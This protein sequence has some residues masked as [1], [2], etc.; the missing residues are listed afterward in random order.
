MLQTVA[1]SIKLSILARDDSMKTTRGQTID[2]LNRKK[3]ESFVVATESM[4][5]KD[6]LAI[7]EAYG[8]ADMVKM[9]AGSMATPPYQAARRRPSA[10][11]D[12][13]VS[14]LVTDRERMSFLHELESTNGAG[15]KMSASALVR[16]KALSS[17]DIH[18]WRE[19]ADGAL[20]E[21]NEIIDS[22]NALNREKR[23]LQSEIDNSDDE[24]DIGLAEERV[25]EINHMLS[26]LI[27]GG[28]KRRV[29]LAGR[30]STPEAEIIKWRSAR[31]YISISDY[32]RFLVFD[33]L[34]NSAADAHMGVD[35]RRR[36]YVSIIDVADNGWGESPHMVSCSQCNNYL[37]EI[38]KLQERIRQLENG[39]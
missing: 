19:I 27:A 39:H 37:G 31:L 38:E 10:P 1:L 18:Q 24:E 21:L 8:R 14:L 13:R 3:E 30:L 22:K 34:P 4:L 2:L 35:A 6:K 23:G 36:F 25:S 20:K 32:L 12:Q 29:R 16:S 5:I 9:F 28:E 26:R 11:L 33:N 15:T 7:A 17:I